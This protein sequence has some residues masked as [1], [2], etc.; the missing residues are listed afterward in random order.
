[1]TGKPPFHGIKNN[2]AIIIAV[3]ND[4]TPAPADHPNLDEHDPLWDL[5]RKCWDPDPTAR[6]DI[7]KVIEEVGL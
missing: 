3:N 7:G 4:E 6:P 2:L 5:M 1:M